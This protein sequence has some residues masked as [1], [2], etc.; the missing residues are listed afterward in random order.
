MTP[1]LIPLTSLPA[2]V[3]MWTPGAIRETTGRLVYGCIAIGIESHFLVSPLGHAERRGCLGV[4]TTAEGQDAHLFVDL[5]P[6]PLDA[7]G[8]PTR[9]DALPVLVDMLARAMGRPEGQHTLR[10]GMGIAWLW[11]LETATL[12]GVVT[13]GFERTE[14]LMTVD[15]SSPLADRFALAALLAARVWETPA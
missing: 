15:M 3:P 7:A 13:Y 10:R 14:A 11:R 9:V 8:H 2:T 4:R 5:S 12:D 1:L 6:P